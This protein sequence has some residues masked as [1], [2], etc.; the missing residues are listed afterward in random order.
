MCS[1]QPPFVIFSGWCLRCGFPS[2][3][4]TE[5]CAI[6]RQIKRIPFKNAFSAGFIKREKIKLLHSCHWSYLGYL[7]ALRVQKF[8]QSKDIAVF[9]EN[10][11][12][13]AA[14]LQALTEVE[15]V[16][17][18]NLALNKLKSCKKTAVIYA[19]FIEEKGKLFK[20]AYCLKR[21]YNLKNLIFAAALFTD[22]FERSW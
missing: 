5:R 14:F 4:T 3:A 12:G 22:C 19:P 7:L 11:N 8:L 1:R 16:G 13:L 21:R 18:Y 6:C 17:L 2:L 10:K 15:V 9:Y 20:K